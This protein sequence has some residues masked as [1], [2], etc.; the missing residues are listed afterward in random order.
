MVTRAYDFFVTYRI[1]VSVLIFFA[2]LN[3][4]SSR[5]VQLL[6]AAYFVA[7]SFALLMSFIYLLNKSTDTTE[8]SINVLSGPIPREAIVWTRLAAYLC[9]ILPLLYLVYFLQDMRVLALYLVVA[10][11]GFLYSV[12]LSWLGVPFR[13]KQVLFL[14]TFVSSLI[15]ALPPAGMHFIATGSLG[16]DD[17]MRFTMIFC[18]GAAMEILWDSR[19]MRGDRSAGIRTIP[20]TFGI[21]TA[22]IISMGLLFVSFS[23]MFYTGPNPYAVF[24]VIA[25]VLFTARMNENRG[26]F[27]YHSTVFLWTLAILIDFFVPSN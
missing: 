21:R 8:D 17:L 25:S 9:L 5:Q 7:L 14:K 20:N 10:I 19:D 12:P 3:A 13:F 11:L 4:P 16:M 18:V 22:Q 6:P 23:S 24:A 1:H 15:W 26:A 27:F 2:V